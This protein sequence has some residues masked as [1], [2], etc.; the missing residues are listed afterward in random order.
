MKKSTSLLI[1]ANAHEAKIFEKIGD[2]IFD[3]NLLK[4]INAELDSNHEK[5]GRTFNSTGYIRHGIEPHT[6]RREVERHKFAAEISHFATELEKTN[7]Y[8]GIIVIASHKILAELEATLD[9]QLQ[10]KITHRLAKD[11]HEF[12]N[13]ELKKYLHTAL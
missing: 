1:I 2:K 7:H 5:P 6:D 8:D 4:E 12:S 11:L 13:T 9:N 3:L 10:K